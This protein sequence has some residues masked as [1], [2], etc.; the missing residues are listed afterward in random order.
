MVGTREIYNVNLF[1]TIVGGALFSFKVFPS[2]YMLLVFGIVSPILFTI[3]TYQ[4]IKGFKE[5]TLGNNFPKFLT[6]RY[7][8][9]IAMAID[10]SIILLF[11]LLIYFNILN[12]F[13]FRFLQTVFFPIISL[14]ILRF[15]HLV[16]ETN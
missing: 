10:I 12:N 16:T 13:F 3:C 15:L 9:Y 1:V 5:E 7:S 2:P 11:A 14:S 6:T 4:S 8:T